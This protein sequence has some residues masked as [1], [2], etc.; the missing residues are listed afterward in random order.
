VDDAAA[1]SAFE[2]VATHPMIVLEVTDHGLDGCATAHL[3]T[4]SIPWNFS[5]AAKLI[6]KCPEIS[7][8]LAN[9]ERN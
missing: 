1:T 6:N 9:Y 5:V 7:A 3:A 8:R 2:I 4:G